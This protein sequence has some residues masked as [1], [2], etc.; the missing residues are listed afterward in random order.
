M[1]SRD[2]LPWYLECRKFLFA[3]P[4]TTLPEP[5]MEQN[6]ASRITERNRQSKANKAEKQTKLTMV[7]SARVRKLPESG[8]KKK[9]P[10]F[11]PGG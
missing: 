7:Y 6:L 9:E 11:E 8:S 4:A 3:I 10:P 2:K 5:G 1:K